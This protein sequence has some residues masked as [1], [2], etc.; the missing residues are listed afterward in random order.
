MSEK[1]N[2]GRAAV[3]DAI[4]DD[5]NGRLE[6]K[7]HESRIAIDK[8][9]MDRAIR[10]LHGAGIRFKPK[11]SDSIA[12]GSGQLD[13][14]MMA[15]SGAGISYRLEENCVTRR[16]GNDTKDMDNR[17]SADSDPVRI[18]IDP[19][20]LDL[21]RRTLDEASVPYGTDG[22]DRLIIK[23]RS[24]DG[25]VQALD[26]AGIDYDEIRYGKGEWD[27]AKETATIGLHY[28]QMD[29]ACT[30]LKGKGITPIRD[31][32]H[33]HLTIDW[34]VA[35]DAAALL[36]ANGIWYYVP[37]V[38][39][40]KLKKDPARPSREFT[41]EEL[42]LLKKPLPENPCRACGEKET[43]CGCQYQAAY[44]KAIK[45]YEDKGLYKLALA[46]G[47]RKHLKKEIGTL[48]S[49]LDDIENGLPDALL[50]V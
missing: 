41:D 38:P 22:G 20:D 40:I 9:D 15:L 17:E 6:G 21:V 49:E 1:K 25:A 42:S 11:L 19:E 34:D 7:G 47:R 29:Y 18:R 10:A 13:G 2:A 35:Q 12:I 3:P 36:R 28:W 31:D 8:N 23:P 46:L 43:C 33:H 45:E 27:M 14:A 5:D 37:E 44:H 50:E 16:S 32:A 26:E 24:L 4:G 48:Q 39:E 30:L